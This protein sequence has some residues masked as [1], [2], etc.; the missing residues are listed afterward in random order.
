LASL[1]PESPESAQLTDLQVSR[2]Q[3]GDDSAFETLYQRFAPLLTKRVRRNRLWSVLEAKIQA[4]DIVQEIWARV[5]PAAQKSFTPS[6]PGSFLAFLGTIT[7]RTMVDLLR[8]ATAEKRG[9]SESAR[10]L[11]THCE[12]HG[13]RLPG[14]A[15]A[16]TPTSRARISELE[17]VA[18]QILTEREL[19]AWELVELQ[20]YSAGEAGLAMDCSG[21]AVR[22]LLLRARAKLILTLGEE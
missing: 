2:W 8:S 9:S 12:R 6:G 22:G 15:G 1:P 13:Q 11:D 7:D 16:E 4:E 10:S 3:A 21:S 14:L 19:E 18:R 5:V 17:D 20:D